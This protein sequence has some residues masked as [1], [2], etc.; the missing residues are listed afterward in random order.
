MPKT[1]SL[2]KEATRGID[3]GAPG[4]DDVVKNEESLV[5]MLESLSLKPQVGGEGNDKFRYVF[6]NDVPMIFDTFS[7]NNFVRF[8]TIPR[9]IKDAGSIP[10]SKVF[11]L[12]ANSSTVGGWQFNSQYQ[13]FYSMFV[14]EAKITNKSVLAARLISLAAMNNDSKAQLD[15]V[16]VPSN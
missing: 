7:E 2:V 12:I 10:S 1:S 3:I 9:K 4:A 6:V 11:E 15:A 5:K 16:L 8:Y 14:V 13:T